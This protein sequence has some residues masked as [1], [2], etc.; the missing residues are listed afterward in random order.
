MAQFRCSELNITLFS[1]GARHM[2]SQFESLGLKH[3]G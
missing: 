3:P 1:A 2:K